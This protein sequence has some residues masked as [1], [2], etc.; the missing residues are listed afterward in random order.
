M[1]LLVFSEN[2]GFRKQVEDM[3]G[4]TP[5]QAESRW[6]SDMLAN[7]KNGGFDA[8]L[9]DYESWQRCAAMFRYFECLDALNQKPMILF[10][11]GRKAPSLK[12]RRAKTLTAHCPLPIQGEEFQSALQQISAAA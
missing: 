5:H 10:S 12:L 9:V 3:L 2:A 6:L 8:M 1:K 4:H 11:K 7:G